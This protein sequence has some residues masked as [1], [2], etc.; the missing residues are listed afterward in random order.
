M[1]IE[2]EITPALLE[3]F[4]DSKTRSAVNFMVNQSS[5]SWTE[6]S[7]NELSENALM[8]FENYSNA[9]LFSR[10]IQKDYFDLMILIWS[11]TWRELV[12]DK[13]SDDFTPAD[14]VDIENVWKESCWHRKYLL[15]PSINSFDEVW[16]YS[17][18]FGEKNAAETFRF[19][20]TLGLRENYKLTSLKEF[21]PSGWELDSG[22]ED[23]IYNDCEVEIRGDK[24]TVNLAIE[25]MKEAGEFLSEVLN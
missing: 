8:E 13:F 6:L 19:S 16:L 14:F 24:L 9:W 11:K 3:Y 23:Y 2:V 17:E 10:K 12:K 15:S 18:L 4:T 22:G 25:V 5:S 1:T 21:F 7:V 20:L